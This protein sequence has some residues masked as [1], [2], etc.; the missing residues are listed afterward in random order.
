MLLSLLY[1]HR[2]ATKSL[3]SV[4]MSSRTSDKVFILVL[5]LEK[6]LNT[7]NIQS[8]FFVS[9]FILSPFLSY[10][11]FSV[12]HCMEISLCSLRTELQGNECQSTLLPICLNIPPGDFH[13]LT[14][15][16]ILYR[17]CKCKLQ[18]NP[19]ANSV[20]QHVVVNCDCQLGSCEG[21]GG[22]QESTWL[23]LSGEGFSR[24][25]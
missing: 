23:S 19:C 3:I 10:N 8:E 17:Q 25:D 15:S 6:M 9:N 4:N 21:F 20:P 12:S 22:N 1:R 11:S 18:L 7:E 24:N 14:I 5:L 16:I 13:L 2:K